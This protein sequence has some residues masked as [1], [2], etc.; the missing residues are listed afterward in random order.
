MIKPP[1]N[2]NEPFHVAESLEGLLEGGFGVFWDVVMATTSSNGGGGE[3]KMMMQ[4]KTLET[5]I[6]ATFW[7]ELHKRK[8]DVYKLQDDPIALTAPLMPGAP[9]LDLDYR[10]FPAPG[11]AQPAGAETLPQGVF[12]ARGVLVNANTAEQF[13]KLDKRALLETLMGTALAQARTGPAARFLV[14]AHA[15]LKRHQFTYVSAVL[16]V[17]F[18]GCDAAVE[19][20]ARQ[21]TQAEA[22]S[23][24][25]ALASD[26]AKV[27][28]W[29]WV[30]SSTVAVADPSA[31]ALHAGW[32]LRNV[33]AQV[34]LARPDLH[35]K[36][37]T[38]LCVRGGSDVVVF[39]VRLPELKEGVKPTAVGWETPRPRVVSLASAMDPRQLAE[40]AVDL[41]LKLMRWRMFAELDL[42]RVGATRC[43]LL[44][45]GTLGCN[46]ARALVGW[47]IR[48]I[49]FVDNA[50]V[51]FSNPVRQT[52]FTFADCLD[53]GKWKAEAAAARLA[54]VFP[55]VDAKSHVMTIPMPGHAV[56][57]ADEERT[58]QV[59]EQLEAL[60][61]E[62]DV[63]FLLSDSR[64]CRW[65]PS[66]LGAFHR[67]L[68][69]TVGL[70]FDSYVVMRHGVTSDG[71]G[72]QQLGCYFC[73]DVVAPRDSLTDRTLDQACTVTRPGVSMVASALA[74]ELLVSV[75]HHPLGSCAPAEGTC[76]LGSVPHQL[77]GFLSQWQTVPLTGAAYDRCVA[78]STAVTDEYRKRGFAF[79]LEAFNNPT[80]LEDVTGL[81]RMRIEQEQAQEAGCSWTAASDDGDDF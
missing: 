68:I 63:V 36:P 41:N 26:D 80:Y 67:K 10:S 9:F 31:D 76:A 22:A 40:T 3:A 13:S 17:R 33:I 79:L 30:D 74:C 35:S 39:G 52:L 34:L 16:A 77:R 42:Q 53:G 81:T 78:C 37:L 21:A 23:A 49:T 15:D 61:L 51:S 50:R 11:P 2:N 29:S 65:L 25:A 1:K 14:V 24:T 32:P 4:F 72:Q 20:G 7:H 28:G 60:I 47:G 75:L 18:A 66:L 56:C 5:R 71:P 54:E 58:K 64:E 59:V 45:A 70:G 8:L 38:A 44:G 73:S 19:H 46:V 27:A 6:S 12:L 55:G 69:I 43:L 48:R 62:H 57:K